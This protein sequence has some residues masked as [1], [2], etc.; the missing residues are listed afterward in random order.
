MDELSFMINSIFVVQYLLIILQIVSL[1]ILDNGWLAIQILLIV[2]ILGTINLSLIK[3]DYR[4][5]IRGRMRK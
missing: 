3:I 2:L 1:F 4:Q 5:K